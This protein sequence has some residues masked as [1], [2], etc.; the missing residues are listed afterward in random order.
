MT[1]SWCTWSKGDYKYHITIQIQ[2]QQGV[3]TRT[4]DC[5]FLEAAVVQRVDQNAKRERKTK[6]TSARR[7]T[8]RHCFLHFGP[9]LQSLIFFALLLEVCKNLLELLEFI[10]WLVS[11]LVRLRL[12]Q[13]FSESSVNSLLA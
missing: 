13:D 4:Q 8:L 6:L 2:R 10:V 1:N 9:L 7:F 11:A 3:T 12:G 5:Y